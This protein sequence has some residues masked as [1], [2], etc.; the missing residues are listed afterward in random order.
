MAADDSTSRQKLAARTFVQL[1]DSLVDEFDVIELLTIL[2]T[3]TVEL[4]DADAAG[5]LLTD[6]HGRLRVMAA[7]SE[8]AALLELFQIQNEEGPCLDCVRTGRVVVANLEESTEWAA[9]SPEGLAAGF[10][11]VSAWPLRLKDRVLGA[12]NIFMSDPRGPSESDVELA[13]A[14]ADVA[15]IAIV[16]D[17]TARDAALREGQLQRAL[18]SRV[19]IEQAKGMIAER[20]QVD[21]DEAFTLLRG[22]ARGHNLQLTALAIE[23]VAGAVD[24][25]AVAGP[26]R[27]APTDID[28]A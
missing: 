25:A 6:N 13:Q 28:E 20:A 22:Y 8:Q 2:A 9:F 3:R 14:L 18:D 11:S 4:L 21:M 12:M 19:A 15:S 5:I 26:R 17:Q 27:P 16:Q 10:G 1:V 7:S 24:L 23:L